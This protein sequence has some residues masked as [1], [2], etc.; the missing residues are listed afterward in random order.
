MLWMSTHE[1][2]YE[3][4]IHSH[5]PV[6]MCWLDLCRCCWWCQKSPAASTQPSSCFHENRVGQIIMH[7]KGNKTINQLWMFWCL[8]SFCLY[9]YQVHL[10]LCVLIYWSVTKHFC[11]CPTGQN[12]F[13]KGSIFP[14]FQ[15]SRIPPEPVWVSTWSIHSGSSAGW[16][17]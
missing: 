4:L 8:V 5:F 13:S 2:I 14:L 9:L 6:L 11:C 7:N 17:V 16:W 12:V 3:S 1:F 15:N 10:M